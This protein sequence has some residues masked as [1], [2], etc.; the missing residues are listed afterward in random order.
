MTDAVLA[1][2]ETPGLVCAHHHLYSTLARGMPPPVRTPTGFMDILD[3]IWWP[4]DQALDEE[5]IRWSAMLGALEALESGC[6]AII[7]HHES[8]N[9]IEGSLDIVADACATV[10]VRVS[11][12]YGVTDRHGPEGAQRGLAENKRFLSEGG[13]GLVGVHAALLVLMTLSKKQRL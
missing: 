1:P 10:G 6:T 11:C 9:S 12:A 13:R 2:N 5:S 3:L 7:D 8:P 4:L